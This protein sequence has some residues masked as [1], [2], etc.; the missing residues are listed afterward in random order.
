M[1]RK[2]IIVFLALIPVICTTAFG[3]LVYT[4]KEYSAVYNEKTALEVELNSVKKKTSNEIKNLEQKNRSL[5]SQIESLEKKLDSLSKELDETNKNYASDK[6]SLEKQIAILK[7]SGSS[8]EKELLDANEKIRQDYEKQIKDLM[9]TL[10][11]ERDDN[12]KEINALKSR[13]NDEISKLEKQISNLSLD[14]DRIKQLNKQQQNE[15]DRLSNQADEL[16]KQLAAEIQAGDIRLKRF[17]NKLIINIDD[18]ISFDS[19]SDQLKSGVLKS[20]EKI[21]DILAQYPEYL[22][23]IEGHTDN[24][25]IKSR[26]FP[27]NWELSTSRALSVLRYILRNK[28]LDPARFSAAGYGEFQP[29]VSN[30]TNENRALNRRVDIVVYP[31]LSEK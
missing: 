11:K 13:Y 29:V 16:E 12:E 15:L 30:D 24:I 1:K 28:K 4:S 20:L 5:Q 3:K 21:T 6:E 19:G 22:I 23:V 31:R 2:Y 8:R 18:K 7:S 9:A 25:P 17:R 27:D 26:K 10:K 14:L